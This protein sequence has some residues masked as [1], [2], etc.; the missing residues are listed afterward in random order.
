MSVSEIVTTG[1]LDQLSEFQADEERPESIDKTASS[2][3]EHGLGTDFPSVEAGGAAI[4]YVYEGFWSQMGEAMDH[5]D[6][7]DSAE[8]VAFELI[9]ESVAQCEG[10]EEILEDVEK[11]AAYIG[12][13][14][15]ENRI[16]IL[17]KLAEKVAAAQGAGLE[18]SMKDKALELATSPTGRLAGGAGVGALGGAVLGSKLKSTQQVKVPRFMGLGSKMVKTKARNPKLMA[19]MSLLG[20]GAGAAAA[21]PDLAGKAKDLV[22]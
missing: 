17:N 15:E 21:R 12:D 2:L 3:E 7:R 8:K 16:E 6:V 10:G 19:L 20:A 9:A 22:T 1:F 14:D 13:K 5:D 4:N 11:V 18:P